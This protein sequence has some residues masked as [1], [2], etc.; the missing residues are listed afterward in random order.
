MTDFD[1]YGEVTGSIE[2]LTASNLLPCT[3]GFSLTWCWLFAGLL[4]YLDSPL[5][6]SFEPAG[7]PWL[8]VGCAFGSGLLAILNRVAFKKV[9]LR[10]S[11]TIVA[12]A[13]AL[14]GALMLVGTLAASPM[15]CVV[16]ELASGIVLAQSLSHWMVY[17]SLL[18]LR[19][20]TTCLCVSVSLGLFGAASLGFAA[21]ALGIAVRAAALTALPVAATALFKLSHRA[22]SY[23]SE[24]LNPTWFCKGHEL[25][26]LPPMIGGA[27]VHTAVFIAT[28]T[29]IGGE[30]RVGGIPSPAAASTVML[31]CG[32]SSLLALG[33]TFLK[34]FQNST[35]STWC[36]RAYP[37]LLSISL[38]LAAAGCALNLKLLMLA[39]IT[40]SVASF[41]L[42]A[43]LYLSVFMREHVFHKLPAI[44]FSC[45]GLSLCGGA[46]VGW[47][48]SPVISG[49]QATAVSPEAGT[50]LSLAL[51]MALAACGACL[52]YFGEGLSA[53]A[54]SFD[55]EADGADGD[56]SASD[57]ENACDAVCLEYN[58]TKRQGEVLRLL[59]RGRN[60]EYVANLLFIS[61]HTVKCHINTIYHKMEIH[62]KNE[63]IDLV[64][65]KSRSL[66]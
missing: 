55:K 56:H 14:G 17:F 46:L 10:V 60:A 18:Y 40:I 33:A 16:G 3:V 38:A 6:G 30:L 37:P 42:C 63:L 64:E 49:A 39:A 22:F 50:C 36:A 52:F 4:T 28:I 32:A 8:L 13:G 66:G 2:H 20:S 35:V 48:C 27:A 23:P 54:L 19:D 7:V 25:H 61:K 57:W 34:A 65:E 15:L 41:S 51:L 9:A 26:K 21:A 47:A 53:P 62:S 5:R 1:D 44:S 59:A 43:V 29:C 58:L 31:I 24:G 12:I 11:M 45:L